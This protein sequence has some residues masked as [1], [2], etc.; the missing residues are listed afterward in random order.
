MEMRLWS[1]FF[2]AGV[3]GPD[4]RRRLIAFSR[5]DQ[6]PRQLLQLNADATDYSLCPNGEPDDFL[7]NWDI[8]RTI[9]E[10]AGRQ[11]SRSEILKSWP[12]DVAKPSLPI[13]HRWL[14]RAWRHCL[15]DKTGAGHKG[16]PFRYWLPYVADAAPVR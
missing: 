12:H 13:L 14:T 9:L 10:N 2:P 15:V 4:R 16:D 11:L 5:F 8:L 1:R 6:T 3:L 7:R